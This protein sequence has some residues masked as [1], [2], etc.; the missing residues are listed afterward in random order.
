MTDHQRA[1]DITVRKEQSLFKIN[2]KNRLYFRATFL[3]Q[4]Y[5]CSFWTYTR[6]SS[7]LCQT[8]SACS[9]LKKNFSSA[10]TRRQRR[11]AVIIC[12]SEPALR[13]HLLFALSKLY[14]CSV[15]AVVNQT[16]SN[17]FVTQQQ[18]LLSQKFPHRSAFLYQK[19]DNTK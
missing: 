1:E 9:S 11:G 4:I 16:M 7:E 15:A 14:M 6:P 18:Q 19:S 5:V 17:N 3:P 12:H 10:L 8:P 2:V 13:R